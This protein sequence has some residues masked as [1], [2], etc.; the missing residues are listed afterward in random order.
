MRCPSFDSVVMDDPCSKIF[1]ISPPLSLT[2]ATGDDDD[3]NK[4]E[5]DNKAEPNFMVKKTKL[6]NE[7]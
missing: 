7:Q 4:N 3:T 5:A 1:N 2:A 6:R